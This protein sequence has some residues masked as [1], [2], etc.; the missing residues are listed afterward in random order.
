M[1]HRTVSRLHLAVAP[2]LRQPEAKNK[3]RRK[4]ERTQLQAGQTSVYGLFRSRSLS[5]PHAIALDD[6][7]RRITYA[8][9]L[10]RVDRLSGWLFAR[11]IGRGDRV[12]ILS[13]NRIEYVELELAAAAR[14]AIVA[15]LNWRLAGPELRHCVEL[16]SPRLVLTEP[17]LAPALA[18]IP[19]IALFEFGPGYEANIQAASP[20]DAATIDPE[21]GLVL[22]YTSGTTG[23]PKAALVSH[24]AM[25]ARAMLY[26]SELA[27]PATDA[28]IAWAPFF[29]MV[30][31][32]H[33][34]ATLLRGG[35]VVIIDGYR[36]DALRSAISRYRISWLVLIPGMIEPFIAE[37]KANPLTPRGIGICGAMA[38][39]VPPHQIAEVT[40]LLGAPYLNTFGSTETGLAPATRA[41]IPVGTAPERLSKQLSAFCEV[42][43]VDPED[44]EVPPGSPGEMTLRGPT[45]FSGYWNATETNAEDFRGGWFHMGDVFRQSP[46]GTVDFVDRAKY[47]IKTGGENVYP[48]EIERVLIADSRV[49]DVA[50]VRASDSRWGEAPVAFISRS[51]QSLTEAD[52]MQRCRDALAGYKRPRE[53]RFIDFDEFPRSTSG[54]IQRHTLEAWLRDG[55]YRDSKPEPMS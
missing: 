7:F 32:D 45:L 46:D 20:A 11:G 24:R 16:V 14:G 53:I 41:L 47:L 35:T 43:L 31:T 23:L 28:F 30:S 48:A 8:Q 42:R 2:E 40:G 39:L 4:M 26:T 18:E 5:S 44:N 51:D 38:D 12:A 13:R 33:A 27:I 36:A 37:L 54:K 19:D 1:R 25:I 9:L 29:H 34:L 50:V 15:C 55:K 22:L 3:D 21:D 49:T 17:D 10:D 52:L 6:G